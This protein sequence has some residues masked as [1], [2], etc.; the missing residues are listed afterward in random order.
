MSLP[1]HMEFAAYC[2]SCCWLG[3]YYRTYPEYVEDEIRAS[4]KDTNQ[5]VVGPKGCCGPAPRGTMD[6]D[7]GACYVLDGNYVSGRWP[8]D[9]YLVAKEFVKLLE[10]E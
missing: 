10:K 3:S 2:I 4:L 9:A 6:D 8:G 5:Y 7:T 1:K